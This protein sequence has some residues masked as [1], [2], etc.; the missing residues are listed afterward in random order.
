MS[1]RVSVLEVDWY[2]R[3]RR[4]A[5]TPTPRQMLRLMPTPTLTPAENHDSSL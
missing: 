1:R 3:A 4:P 2:E 5:L